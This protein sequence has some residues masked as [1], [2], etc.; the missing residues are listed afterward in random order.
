MIRAFCTS[1][2]MVMASMLFLAVI[3]AFA[4]EIKTVI[5][6]ISE[7]GFVPST[8]DLLQ[9]D[10][11]VFRNTGKRN[12][13]PASD[14]H[15]THGIYP[16]FDSLG[17]IAPGESW[18]FQ[19][20]KAGDWGLHD[21]I[22]AEFTGTVHVE[23]SPEFNQPLVK[24]KSRMVTVPVAIVRGM[25]VQLAKFFYAVIPIVA[26]RRLASLDLFSI[27]DDTDELS[28]WLHIFG[29]TKLMEH[30]L[31]SA[32]NGAELDCH[33]PAHIIGRVSYELLGMEAF[34]GGSPAC[35]SGYY[36]GA[37]EGLLK[38]RGV[39]KLPETVSEA[40][41]LF[42]TD[43]SKFSCLHGVGHG[44]LAY[45]NYDVPAALKLCKEL[46]T[47]YDQTSCYGGV[48]MENIV[49]GQGLGAESDH[50]TEWVNQTDPHFPCNKIDPDLAVQIQCYQMQTSWMLTLAKYDIETVIRQCQEARKDMVPVCFRSLGRDIAG[51]TLRNPRKIIEN[52]DKVPAL[53]Y[54]GCM[55]GA[56]N[57][58]VDFWGSGLEGQ[59]SELCA[60]LPSEHKRDCYA[61]IS[62]RL[63]DIQ[64]I[65]GK[66]KP[67]CDTF[68]QKY[69]SLCTE[70]L[71]S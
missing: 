26:D 21:H 54:V 28:Y 31:E 32:G 10:R 63:L 58:I 2:S 19:F 42:D 3:P 1:A 14:I 45:R 48:F 60:L 4:H 29:S 5:V 40:C 24:E 34:T 41:S 57:V 46:S 30:L 59:A 65:P 70:T 35:H 23:E 61:L 11:I 66:R 12:H 68:E 38:V 15:P 69:H 6:E 20:E 9:G 7:D 25:K 62:S 33:Q 8:I 37:M 22:D 52:C 27:T 49:Q 47:G 36:H 55:T 16:E 50:K 64:S 71:A 44:V 67:V 51:F 13:W 56:L 17:G 53:H 18:T 43:F 39:S